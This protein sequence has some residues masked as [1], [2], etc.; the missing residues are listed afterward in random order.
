MKHTAKNLLLLVVLL[1]ATATAWAQSRGNLT[2]RVTDESGAPL[3]GATVLIKGTTLGTATELDGYYTLRG[4]TPGDSVTVTVDYLGYTPVSRKVKIEAGKT[5]TVN[6]TMKQLST[7]IEGVVVSAVVDGQ[8]RALNQQR[9]ADNMMQVLS[10]DQMGRFPD[11]NVTDALRR[12]SGVTSDGEQ[13]QMRGTPGN[14][15]NININ[16][17]QLMGS[18]EGGRRNPNLDVI[19][20]DVLASME[21]QKTLLPS[22]DGDAIAG[23][24]N[25][26]T[27]TARSLSPSFKVDLGTG[28]NFLREKMAW[29]G[30]FNYS[31]RFFANNK[32]PNGRFGISANYSY[33]NTSDGY[34]RLEAQDWQEQTI[35]N[36]ETGE[37]STGYV[38]TDFRYR[39]QNTKNI[40]QGAT[41]TLDY[42]PNQ[43]TQIVFS[44]IFNQFTKDGTRYRNRSRFRGNYYDMGNGVLGADRIRNV[45]QVTDSYET[46]NN[47]SFNLDGET[48]LGSWKIDAGLFYSQSR[49]FYKSQMNG[50]QTPEWRAGKTA[51]GI[52]IPKGTVVATMPSITTKY[53]T[54]DYYNTDAWM[55]E[56]E[57]APNA[58]ERYNLYISENWDYNNEA[59]NFTARGNASYNYFIAD[60]FA[61]TFSFGAK[62]KFMYSTGY[63]PDYCN[64]Y[65]V[66]ASDDNTLAKMLYKTQLDSKWLDGHIPFGVAPDLGKVQS[67]LASNPSEVTVNEIS[68]NG[69]RDGYYYNGRENIGAFY[70]MNKMQFNK[71]MV[72]VG[73]RLENTKVTY[74]ANKITRIYDEA[75]EDFVDYTKEPADSTLS[76]VK[77]LPNVQFKWDVNKNTIFRLA[78]TTGYSRPNLNELVP[79]QDMSIDPQQVTLGNPNLKPAYAHNLDF[80]FERYLSNVGII[81]GGV[82]YK[83]ISGFHYLSQGVARDGQFGDFF[84]GWRVTQTQN[85][86]DA[87]I[88][89]A[90]ITLNS[91]LTFLP[92]FL[93]NLVFTSNYTYVHS[94]AQTDVARGMTRLPGQADHTA[95]IALAYSSKRLTLQAAFNYNGSYIVAFGSNPE[96]DQWLDGRWQMDVNGSFEICKGL[97]FWAEAVNVLNAEKYT[98]IGNKS[99]VY[100]LQYNGAYGRLGFTYRF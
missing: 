98:Y 99:R 74:K 6:F 82:F 84:N 45:A 94:K 65:D 47:L 53:L 62:G 67:Y 38:P 58:L 60:K 71:L 100:E 8:Q 39:Y 32:N 10:A 54:M 72:L 43:N 66:A 73:A 69:A 78:W 13:V 15:T 88:F 37:E 63:V 4:I 95:N 21:V 59:H 97:T 96:E 91:S 85:G 70:V 35:T 48:T 93:K 76:Y 86:E 23:V 52:A 46:N 40:R 5:A 77:F 19:P 22:N 11:L 80:L 26:R 64:I 83:H 51:A 75:E 30:K 34:D 87:N 14:F 42:A 29:N 33:F 79:K 17:E 57:A 36:N 2:G 68:S 20:S 44:T 7:K 92:G 3:P 24:I 56:G 81:S 31:Q 89:G 50:F 55:P 28:Y 41:L 18:Y 9:A 12:L 49:T 16:G 25:L 90:E 27:S 1:T 61:S